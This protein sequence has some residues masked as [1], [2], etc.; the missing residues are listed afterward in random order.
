MW[1]FEKRWK[2]KSEVEKVLYVANQS[3]SGITMSCLSNK[4]GQNNSFSLHM[5]KSANFIKV[6]QKY[7]SW[8]F[9][10]RY[11]EYSSKRIQKWILCFFTTPQCLVAI[12]IIFKISDDKTEK[13]MMKKSLAMTLS[14][15]YLIQ[16]V[17]L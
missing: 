12:A 15:R 6:I 3:C 16:Y 1:I 13:W 11:I 10:Y 4:S 14:T 5:F 9:I 17:V 8:G 7:I 2:C